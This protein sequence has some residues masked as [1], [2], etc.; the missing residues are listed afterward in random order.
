MQR[1]ALAAALAVLL[2]APA[3]AAPRGIAGCEAISEPDAYN[4][5]LA[6]FGPTRRGGGKLGPVPRGA[7]AQAAR[8]GPA[9]GPAR[10]NGVTVERKGGRVR[11]TIDLK[12]K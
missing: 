7:R 12:R 10:H 9:A 8:R 6:S 3:L 5:C 4:K 11:A 2:F 1:L